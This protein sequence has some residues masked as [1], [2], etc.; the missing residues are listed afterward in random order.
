MSS[1]SDN[2]QAISNEMTLIFGILASVFAVA[3][4]LLGIYQYRQFSK[5]SLAARDLEM[6]QTPSPSRTGSN[7]SSFSDRGHVPLMKAIEAPQR[8]YSGSSTR[9]QLRIDPVGEILSRQNLYAGFV[10][11]GMQVQAWENLGS[12][13]RGSDFL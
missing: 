7:L 12:G 5:T 2:Q 6:Q 10:G 8:T 9:V 3:S 1:S 4:V 11:T 13:R